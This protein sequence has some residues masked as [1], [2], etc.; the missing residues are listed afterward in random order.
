MRRSPRIIMASIL[1]ALVAIAIYLQANEKF[2]YYL[3]VKNRADQSIVVRAVIFDGVVVSREPMRFDAP[4]PRYLDTKGKIIS[5]APPELI[6]FDIVDAA[7]EEFIT[8]CRLKYGVGVNKCVL[9]VDF[10]PRSSH[11]NCACDDL[12]EM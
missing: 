6:S 5:D 9:K 10:Y 3:A 11:A 7:G 2:S 8:S 1:L 4:P 12:Q